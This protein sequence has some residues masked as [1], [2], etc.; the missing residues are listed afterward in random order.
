LRMSQPYVEKATDAGQALRWSCRNLQ[1]AFS[2]SCHAWLITFDHG[3][4]V[5]AREDG[6]DGL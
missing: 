3:T 2:R 1:V 4:V 5:M 6:S